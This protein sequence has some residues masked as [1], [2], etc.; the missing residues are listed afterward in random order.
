[1]VGSNID[2]KNR[3]MICPVHRGKPSSPE[4][5]TPLEL[6]VRIRPSYD[7]IIIGEGSAGCVLGNR[8]NEDPRVNVLLLEAGVRDRNPW[9]HVPASYLKP[10]IIRRLT[11]AMSLMQ[12]R[13]LMVAS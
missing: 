3:L 8:L 12:T 4:T 1:V 7:C 11:G 5:T 6:D 10:C 9:I 13:V 2:I